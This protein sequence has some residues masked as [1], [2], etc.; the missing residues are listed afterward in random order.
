MDAERAVVDAAGEMM[1]PSEE[2]V[3]GFEG[4]SNDTM[5]YQPSS[6]Q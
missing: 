4:G 2:V 1:K 3:Q 6:S 5:T